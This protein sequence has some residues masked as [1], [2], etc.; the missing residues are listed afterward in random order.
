MDLLI[1]SAIKLVIYLIAGA[2]MTFILRYFMGNTLTVRL[3]MW[4]I[5]G[6]SAAILAGFMSGRASG[7]GLGWVAAITTPIAM[8]ILITNI[9]II[10]KKL[11]AQIQQIADDLNESAVEMNS[12]SVLVSNATENLAE[13]A[14]SQA[15]AIEES[16]SALEEMSAMTSGNAENANQAKILTAETRDIVSKVNNHM[17]N[18]ANAIQKVTKTSEETGKII[19]TIDEIAFQTNLLALNAAVEAARAGEAGAG[20][21]VVADEVRNLAQRSAEAAKSTASLIENTITVVKESSDLT[22]LTQTAFQ[23]NVQIA[24]KVEDLVREIAAASDEQAQ[25]I[26]QINK[27]VTQLDR[28]T[29]QN[30]AT[31][32]ESASA[33]EEMNAQSVQMKSIVRRLVVIIQGQVNETKERPSPAKAQSHEPAQKAAAPY[34]MTKKTPDRALPDAGKK[35]VSSPAPVKKSRPEEVIPF[36]HDD[37]KDF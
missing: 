30:A 27:A 26:N 11:I 3:F 17:N 13:G 6:V 22:E 20:F 19:K 28:V 10:G 34:K 5:P 37:F 12:A 4:M 25:G 24:K 36:E 15:S 29:Q 2:F 14:S 1:E 32:E 21:A 31:A 33:A 8:L 7:A 35:P 16:S 18:M 23:E 9:V